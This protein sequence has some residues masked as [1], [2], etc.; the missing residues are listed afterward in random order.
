M[1]TGMETETHLVFVNL[2]TDT[3][4]D[5]KHDVFVI[6]P[7]NAAITD[8]DRE[9][10]ERADH[11][12]A[13]TDDARAIVR[14]VG[15]PFSALWAAYEWRQAFDRGIADANLSTGVTYGS[16]DSVLS[17]AYDMGR[18]YGET[19]GADSDDDQD[20][21]NRHRCAGCGVTGGGVVNGACQDCERETAG[22][23]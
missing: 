9:I 14:R 22:A 20:Y 12:G 10:L 11:F 4:E 7:N 6:D 15:V 5:C 23:E 17:A 18:N 2:D 8:T 3:V 21:D 13:F 1:G 19:A 16:P